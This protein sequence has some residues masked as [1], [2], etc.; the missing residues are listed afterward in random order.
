[1]PRAIE[2]SFV[3]I[4]SDR[5]KSIIGTLAPVMIPPPLAPPIP[6]SDL[7]MKFIEVILGPMKISVLPAISE[8][9]FFVSAFLEDIATSIEIGPSTVNEF[10]FR[11]FSAIFQI[12]RASCRERV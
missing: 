8:S 7:T 11:Y 4:K 6:R 12:G 5:D 2:F 1:M 10:E 9:I 3:S